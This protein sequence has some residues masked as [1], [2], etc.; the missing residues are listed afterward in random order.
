MKMR[1]LK[2][3][4]GL[5][6]I[7]QEGRFKME[8][9]NG[10]PMLFVLS[11]SANIEPQ[12]LGDLQRAQARLTVRYEDSANLIAGIAHDVGWASPTEGWADP[13]EGWAEETKA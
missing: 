1:A 8:P 6:T 5:I 3:M 7:A 13:T 11:P 4:T 9:E 10:Q 2:T 12:D